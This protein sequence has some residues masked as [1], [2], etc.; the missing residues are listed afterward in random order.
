[1]YFVGSVFGGI[2]DNE[3]Y[4]IITIIDAET[5]TIST[6]ADPLILSVTATTAISNLVTVSSTLELN[7]NDPI[8]FTGTTFGD[9]NPGTVYYIRS[10]DS[11]TTITIASVING[12]AV[13]LTTASGSCTL[14]S[15][16]TAVQLTTATGSM[17]MIFVDTMPGKIRHLLLKHGVN[18]SMHR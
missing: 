13:P 7:V 18:G 16:T 6:E 2:I 4:Y 10:V 14:T 15:Q 8:I 1:V 11:G 12:G 3:T 17:T 5:F 9:I